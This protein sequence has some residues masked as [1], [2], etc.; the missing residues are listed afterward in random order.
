MPDSPNVGDIQPAG[1]NA[2]PNQ[3]RS[4]RERA[5]DIAEKVAIGD[6]LSEYERVAGR[7]IPSARCSS[8]LLKTR[9]HSRPR[10]K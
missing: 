8:P 5:D 4:D 2:N 3:V 10:S 6:E 9:P 1:E 7:G